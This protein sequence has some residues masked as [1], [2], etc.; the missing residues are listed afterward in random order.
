MERKRFTWFILIRL[1]V[2]SF[3]LV[4]TIVLNLKEPE[5]INVRALSH[6]VRLIIATY[7]FSILSL[8]YIRVTDRHR[9]S[10]AYVQIIWDLVFVTLLILITGGFV[11]PFSFLYILSIANASTF[12]S[13]REAYYT[14]SLCAILHGGMLVTQLYGMLD[15]GGIAFY[16][17]QPY[18]WSFSLYTF[19]VNVVAFF[20]TAFLTGQLAE[21]IRRTETA[22]Q[23]REIDYEE[24]ERLHGAIVANINSGLVTV[25]NQGRI[26]VFNRFAEQLTGFT[27]AEAYDRPLPG[28]FPALKGR[29]ID[30]FSDWCGEV[31]FKP[32]LE[33]V[34]ILGFTSSPLRGKDGGTIG[35]VISFTDLTRV[36]KMEEE[37][38]RA[39]R[40]AAI[41][42]L[43]AR[44]AHE[45]RN[46]L[47]S[48]SGSVQLLAQSADIALEDRRLFDIVIRE[49]DRLNALIGD[50]LLYARPRQPEKS[51]VHL[52][53]LLAEMKSILAGD[54][55]FA[56]ITINDDASTDLCI[57]VDRDL[58]K[59][60]LWNLFI[61]AA[62]AMPDGG[63]I[64]V[65][66]MRQDNADML[67]NARR[68]VKI[69]VADNGP[70]MDEK[71]MESIFE[72]FFTTKGE[73]S[74]LGLATVYR[75]VESHGGGIRVMSWP[76]KGTA[77]DLYLADERR[78]KPVNGE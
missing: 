14:A 23:E 17:I 13:R 60:V 6:L 33:P 26:R 27:Q 30:F 53:E 29:A 18:N 19:L 36:K 21:R 71:Q 69:T 47:A 48:I 68:V 3:F 66:A 61:N 49:A 28:I 59:Q 22:L 58:F 78:E 5:S 32:L 57:S 54:P 37:L 38:K 77:F 73:G 4:L 15:V 55:K 51:Q 56:G 43:S 63:K 7:L 40:L 9:K 75:I 67:I 12:L 34:R 45:I 41:G 16:V 2:V 65:R 24:L 1:L 8:L 64:W 11:S 44:M 42:Q 25:T 31:R 46:P 62:E 72:P 50:F 10:F 52:N 20:L 35:A 39:D 76:A 74:G 70:G